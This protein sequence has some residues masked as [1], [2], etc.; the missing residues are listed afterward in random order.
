MKFILAS[1]SPSRKQ[2]F[3]LLHIPFEVFSPECDESEYKNEKPKDY[4]QRIALLKNNTAAQYFS[5]AYILSADTV[6]VVGQHVLHKTRDPQEAFRHLHLLSGRRHRVYT[7]IVLSSPAGKVI[8]RLVE[9]RV[10]FNQVTAHQIK[11]FLNTE[12]WKDKAGSYSI[13]G[14]A[15]CFIR[16]IVG[17]PSTIQGL[18]MFELS[19]ILKG[20]AIIPSKF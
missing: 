19:Q 6:V 13:F 17:N 3:G 4:V 16:H 7:A 8:R 14:T 15:C 18:P 1:S 2:L 5:E 12:E 11:N 9:A 10:T 20:L